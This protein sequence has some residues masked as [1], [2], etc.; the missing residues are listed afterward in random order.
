MKMGSVVV[1]LVEIWG[2]DAPPGVWGVYDFYFNEIKEIE[3]SPVTG[4]EKK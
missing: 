4:K 3:P 2:D 1:A